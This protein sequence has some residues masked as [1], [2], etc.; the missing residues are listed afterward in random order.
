[1]DGKTATWT[2]QEAELSAAVPVTL[3][4]ELRYSVARVNQTVSD[5]QQTIEELEA[6]NARLRDR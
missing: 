1:M 5:P 3:V 6:G 2:G 4:R